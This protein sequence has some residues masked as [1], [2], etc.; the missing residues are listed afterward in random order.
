MAEQE[1]FKITFSDGEEREELRRT[2]TALFG[3]R[4]GS[5]PGDRE[6]G[7]SWECLD[8]LPDVAENLFYL[9][10]LKKVEKYEPRAEISDIVFEH[11]EG[12]LIP[13]LYFTGKEEA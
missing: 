11:E 1:D 5:M 12:R 2:L 7:I 3:I 13:H 9:E 8:E 10:A 4:A 6:F